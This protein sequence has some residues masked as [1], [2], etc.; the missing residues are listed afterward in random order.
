MPPDEHQE[1]AHNSIYTNLVANLAVNTA[2][3]AT[4]LASGEGEAITVIPEEW[5]YKMSNLVFLFNEDRR[6]HE[7][8]EGFNEQYQ[9]GEKLRQAIDADDRTSCSDDSQAT[10]IPEELSKLTWFFW[11]IHS[12][13]TCRRMLKGT[14]L[15]SMSLSQTQ[16]DPQ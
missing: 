6:Y 16:M 15:T 9:T 5:L 7:E 13:G 8:Y 1:H 11:D 10:L 14:I 3:W 12:S 2:R 4:C